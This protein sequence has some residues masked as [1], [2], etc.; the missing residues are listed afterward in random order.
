MDGFSREMMRRVHIEVREHAP[1]IKPMRD[2][3]VY[4]FGRNHYE[5]HGPDGFYWHGR[6]GDA[7]DARAKGWSAWLERKLQS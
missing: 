6:A 7:Y 4:H 1:S 3:W 5:F 2:A